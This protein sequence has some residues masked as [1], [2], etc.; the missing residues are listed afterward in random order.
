MPA[1]QIRQVRRRIR[2]VESTGKVTRAMGLV[3]TSRILKAQRRLAA[4]R[5]YSEEISRV[6]GNL[7]VDGGRDHRLLRTRE[8]IRRVGLVVLA[9]DRGLAGAYNANVL[10]LAERHLRNMAGAGTAGYAL[11]LV[12]R[13]AEA[14]FRYRG[15]EIRTA[16]EG[17]SDAPGYEDARLVA[18]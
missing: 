5:P 18:G 4:A 1:A 16:H 12:G 11:F 7:V 2:S 3:A 9:A 8:E 17:V 6:V 10:R 13:K 14:Y 15:Y